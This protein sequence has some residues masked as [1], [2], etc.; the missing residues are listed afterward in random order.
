MERKREVEEQLKI[1]KK[2]KRLLKNKA[3]NVL[4]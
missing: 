2:C 4:K 1:H 3:Q